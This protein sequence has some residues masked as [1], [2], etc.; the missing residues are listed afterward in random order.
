MRRQSPFSALRFI[1]IALVLFALILTT[2]ELVR[3]SRVRAYLPAG[4]KIGGVPVG[5]LDRQQAAQRLREVYSTPIEVRYNGAAIQMS[6]TVADF[7]MDIE[8]MLAIAEMERSRKLFWQDFWDYLWNR[9]SSPANIPLSATTSEAR[10]RTFLDEISQRY[11]RAPVAA[12]PVPGT[13][14]FRPGQPGVSL[15]PEGSILLIENA[16]FS[17]TNRVVDLPIRRTNPSRPAFQNLEVQLKQI[18]EVSG[19]EGVAGLYL[20]DLQSAQEIHFAVRGKEALAVKPDV[21]F[22]ASSIIKLPIMISVFRRMADQPDAESLRMINDMVVNSGNE[23]ADWLMDRVVDPAR[24]PL[25]VT[26]DLRA[27]GLENTFLA[28]YFSA[29]SPLLAQIKTPANQRSDVNTDPDPY[30]QTTPSD[31]GMLLEDLYQCAQNGGGAL[32][33][34]FPG[35]INQAKC[36]MMVQYLKNNAL[37]WLLT[38]GIPDGTVIAHKHGWV[39]SASGTIKTIGDAGII[40]TPRGNYVLVVFLNHPEEL[41]FEPSATLV[42]QLSAAVYTY[43]NLPPAE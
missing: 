22:T 3:F 27:L 6:P 26:E 17:L 33:A 40:Y 23:V 43:Y 15:D 38:A 18:I 21:A 7:R 2:M 5:G 39:S 36:Q 20:I 11:D 13:I 34:V 10:I 8:S 9:S 37:L 30:N 4:M 31:I 32:V 29:G 1:S 28:G 24:G 42:A 12:Q 16:L 19:F 41:I 14:N 25:L 35:Q